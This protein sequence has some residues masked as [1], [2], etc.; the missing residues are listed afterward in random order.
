MAK[1]E[2]ELKAENRKLSEDLK[3]LA[4]AHD[5]M[6][7]DSQNQ[8]E[9]LKKENAELARKAE[10]AKAEAKKQRLEKAEECKKTMAVKIKESKHQW[11]RVFDTGLKE[12]VDFAFNYEGLQIRLISGDPVHLS[13]ILINHLK[14]CGYPKTQLKQ[15]EAGGTIKVKGFHHRFNV[16]PCEPPAKEDVAAAV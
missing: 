13:E 3:K 7:A 6:T 16:V 4:K 11:V 2:A 14:H 10:E 5:V 8:I 9:A 12:G 15:G 1:T